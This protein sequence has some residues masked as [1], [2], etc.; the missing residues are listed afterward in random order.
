MLPRANNTK[1]S[2]FNASPN[3]L[4]DDRQKGKYGY[5]PSLLSIVLFHPPVAYYLKHK[6]VKS[7]METELLRKYHEN[8]YRDKRS[9][10]IKSC[11]Y[12]FQWA[13]ISTEHNH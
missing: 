2:Q 1:L 5:L 12:T 6:I 7:V 13:F 10:D 3:N 4:F 9:R 11:Y 8:N